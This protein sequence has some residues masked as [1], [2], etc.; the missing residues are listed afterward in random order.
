[1]E[2]SMISGPAIK[3]IASISLISACIANVYAQPVTQYEYDAN[4]NRTKLTD[5]LLN[6]T[7]YAYDA[8]NRPVQQNQ[9]NP[10]SAGQLG[11]IKTEYNAI[12]Q[13]TKITDPR[14]L[15][16]LYGY[17]AFGNV[18]SLTSPDTGNTVNTYDDAGNILTKRDAKN[19]TTTYTYDALNRL[20]RAVYADATEGLWIQRALLLMPTIRTGA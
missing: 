4:G 1:G 2:Y 16:T 13:I 9:P 19:Q 12:N 6:V 3:L 18:Q 7:T 8:L 17:N 5:P 20:T 15:Q 14:N 10:A 11:Q